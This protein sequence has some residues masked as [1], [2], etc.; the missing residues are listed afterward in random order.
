MYNIHNH[1]HNIWRYTK[2][3]CDD[4]RL[5]YL[6]P[7]G[8]TDSSNIEILADD[9]PDLGPQQRGPLIICYDQEPLIWGFNN[10]LFD[11]ILQELNISDQRV[12]LLN[13]EQESQDKNQF[14]MRYRFQD[15]YSFF[16][17]FAA[18]DWYRGYRYDVSIKAPLEREIKKKYI[19]FNRLTGGARVYRSMLVAELAAAGVIKHGYI[20]YSERCP[21]YGHYRDNLQ[22][23]IGRYNINQE[24]ARQCAEQL[25]NI[26]FPL[27]IDSQQGPIPNGS[28]TLGAI[29]ENMESFLHIVTETCYWEKKHH[30]TE[31]I[32][33]PI[34]AR[35]PFVLLAPRNNL[36]YLK[37][38]GFRT[39][40]RW[41]DESYDEIADPVHRLQAV[42]EIV[43]SLCARS[44]QELTDLLHEM[45]DTLE[46]NYRLLES[47][48]T[49]TRAW[50][51]LKTNLSWCLSCPN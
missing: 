14:L 36:A 29:R 41:W 26:E 38:Y 22:S 25:D 16:H 11:H 44:D 30:L 15:C 34:I 21:L 50:Q 6:Y 8:S 12:I 48:Q 39:F 13:T 37:S 20:S 35:Q 4:P 46:H 51:E 24:Y 10:Q 18:S 2:T 19:T 28:M 40:D 27:R 31:K 23:S 42:V 47:G 1:Y 32:F 3:L 49:L 17:V 45:N 33:K 43:K 9:R 5:V 7:F